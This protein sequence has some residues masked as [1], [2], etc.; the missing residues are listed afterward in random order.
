MRTLKLSDSE[1]R[2]LHKTASPELKAVL[3]SEENF[4]KEFFSEKVTDRVKT[5]EDAVEATGRTNTPDFSNVPEDLRKYFEGQYQ[6]VVIAEALNEGWKPDWDD[7]NQM[8]W[9]PWFRSVSSGFVFDDA[10][11]DYSTANAGNGLRLCFKSE[12]LAAYA[13]KQFIEIWNKILLK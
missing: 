10:S 2:A 8:K 13:G 5:Y 7:A 3:E 6:M 4:G 1:A 12:E 11:D 9:I